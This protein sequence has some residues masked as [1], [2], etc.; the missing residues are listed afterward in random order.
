MALQFIAGGS[1][2]G[3][4]HYIYS[5]IIAESVED[6]DGRY[7]VMVPEQF[8]MQ[9]QKELVELHPAHSIMNIDVLSFNSLAKRVFEETGFIH[10]PILEDMG[11]TVIEGDPELEVSKRFLELARM[12]IEE[13][14]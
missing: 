8:T 10:E 13:D 4:S 1:G 11:K 7:F 9:T 12:L 2:S 14:K 3:K 6:K 5:R